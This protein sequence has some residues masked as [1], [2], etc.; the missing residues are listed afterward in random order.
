MK[1]PKITDH[2]VQVS[3]A[4]NTDLFR[5]NTD[6][7]H[8]SVLFGGGNPTDAKIYLRVCVCKTTYMS[9]VSNVVAVYAKYDVPVFWKVVGS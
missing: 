2:T 5:E 1:P 6:A 7:G 4:S 3:I 8:H 9:I